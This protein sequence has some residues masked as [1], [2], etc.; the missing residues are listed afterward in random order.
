M[1]AGGAGQFGQRKEH[2]QRQ[3]GE[4]GQAWLGAKVSLPQDIMLSEISQ[5]PKDKYHV[6]PLI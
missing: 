3:G 4:T 2:Q 1:T 5:S 6:I